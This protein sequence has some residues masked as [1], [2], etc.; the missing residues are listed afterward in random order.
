MMMTK[1]DTI[2]HP[3]NKIPKTQCTKKNPKIEK[4]PKKKSVR[5]IFYVRLFRTAEATFIT[6]KLRNISYFFHEHLPP[7]K[8]TD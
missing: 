1:S 8:I 2:S 5:M 6:N 3:K 7:L 4:K